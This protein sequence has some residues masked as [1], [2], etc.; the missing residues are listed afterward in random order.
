MS[1]ITRA[2][3]LAALTSAD[4]P[5]EFRLFNPGVNETA[6]GAFLFDAPAA[7]AVMSDYCRWGVDLMIDL[8]HDSLNDSARSARSDAADALGWFELAV[9][10]DGSLWAVNVRWNAEGQRRLSAKTQR[11]ISPAFSVE[12][13]DDGQER[14][15]SIFNA[16][17]CAAPATF[18]TP[19][20][21]A[22]NRTPGGKP[23]ISFRSPPELRTRLYVLAARR[24]TTLTALLV[25]AMRTLDSTV[26]PT[27]DAAD[28]LR[29]LVEA[30]GLAP[31]ASRAAVL[32][33]IG[34]LIDT[35][36]GSLAPADAP[37]NT[38]PSAAA[39]DS[40]PPAQLS[41]NVQRY[42]DSARAS[43]EVDREVA[44]KH[45]VTLGEA[46]QMRASAAHRL[47]SA[48]VAPPKRLQGVPLETLQARGMTVDE[49]QEKKRNAAR[50]L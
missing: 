7:D 36:T 34:D 20:L 50:R 37:S 9:K 31:D 21:V 27:V 45:G 4:A 12:K 24:N 19:P 15:V 16:A 25:E 33:A 17:L 38:D 1:T 30:L 5:T 2:I 47:G 48:P 42:F 39:P 40:P 41:A 49:F 44:A 10:P 43:S 22:A 23:V 18:G 29:A 11:Y 32:K 8:E 3:T 35:P 6:K 13:T 14:I 26:S 46:R 28:K